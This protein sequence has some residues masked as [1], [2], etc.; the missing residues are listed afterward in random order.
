MLPTTSK[1]IYLLPTSQLDT[2]LPNSHL[3][4]H[5]SH[6]TV[7]IFLCF[8]LHSWLCSDFFASLHQGWG[9]GAGCGQIWTRICEFFTRLG[10][11]SYPGFLKL[12]KQV[13]KNKKVNFFK[14][15]SG[16]KNLHKTRNPALLTLDFV[17]SH[18]TVDFFVS[19][20]TADSFASLL[21]LSTSQL[22]SK[23]I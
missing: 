13:K 19:N 4:P 6:L 5:L 23:L 12:Y 21:V 8:K 3:R 17:A 9:S 2:L 18:L 15:L 20:I 11:R 1:L 14:F 7:H 10:S 22:I 16:N